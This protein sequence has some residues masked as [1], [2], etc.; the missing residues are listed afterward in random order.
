MAV[1]FLASSSALQLDIEAPC[2]PR[3]LF[4]QLSTG[5]PQ[6]AH[7]KKHHLHTFCYQRLPIILHENYND[8]D[9]LWVDKIQIHDMSKDDID[10]GQMT[11]DGEEKSTFVV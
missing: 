1:V 4:P 2:R 11:F 6:L 10:P 5:M 9:V 3:K 8:G 7:G